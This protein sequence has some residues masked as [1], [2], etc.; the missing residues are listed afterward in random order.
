ME[1]DQLS[2]VGFRFRATTRLG[3]PE[4]NGFQKKESIFLDK[5]GKT[6]EKLK[7]FL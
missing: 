4:G 3:S 2:T 1:Q 7:I 6:K 5:G